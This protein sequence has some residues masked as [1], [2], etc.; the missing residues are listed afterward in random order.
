MVTYQVTDALEEDAGPRL[1]RGDE[2]RFKVS[3][4]TGP[5]CSMVQFCTRM[6]CEVRSWVWW[7]RR[8]VLPCEPLNDRTTPSLVS[9][10][11]AW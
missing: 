10:L 3:E 11:L 8:C 6:K 4:V 1:R 2:V 9:C 7:Q 5:Q